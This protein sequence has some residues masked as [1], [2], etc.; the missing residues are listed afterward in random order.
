MPDHVEAEI[1]FNEEG[2]EI[3]NQIT[4]AYETKIANEKLQGKLN[5]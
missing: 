5:I 4:N 3:Y 1:I 2:N